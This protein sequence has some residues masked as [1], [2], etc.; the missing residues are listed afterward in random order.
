MNRGG[1][2]V[3]AITLALWTCGT[4][5]FAAVPLSKTITDGTEAALALAQ[6]GDF[7]AARAAAQ[8]NFDLVIAYGSN[9]DLDAFRAAD[10]ARRL[11]NQLQPMEPAARGD[12]LKYLRAHDELA[13]TLVF[14]ARDGNNIKG[15]YAL[16]DRLRKQRPAQVVE[17]ANLTAAIC[18]VRD[19]PL[20]NP[21]ER[22]APKAVDALDIFDF[23]AAHDS[24][25]F[26]GI[27]GMPVDLLVYVVDTT[28]SIDEMNWALAKY[29][30]TKNIGDLFFT[31]AYDYDFFEGKTPQRRAVVEGY[32]LPN[33]LKFGGICADQAYFATS[34]GKAIGVPTAYTVGESAESG[35]AWVGFLQMQGRTARWNFNS[36]R[37][38]AYQ[39]VRGNA[40]DPQS[41]KRLADS[42]VS[43]LA[44][45]I[46]ASP[47]ARQNAVAMVDAAKRLA[48]GKG[49]DGTY[50]APAS[51]SSSWAHT[52]AR[53]ASSQSELDL[54]EMGLVQCPTYSPGWGLVADLAGQGELTEAQKSRWSALVEQ[55]CGQK[56][57]DFTLAVLEPMVDT[58]ANPAEQ[59]RIWDAAFSEFQTRSDLAAEIRMH[60]ATLWE[61]SGDLAKAGICYEDVIHR[62]INAGPFALKALTGAEEILK[63]MGQEAKVL[64]LYAD[65]AKLV[66]KPDQQMA[67]MYFKESN[68]FKV[69]EAYAKKLDEAGLTNQ[70]SAIRAA[71]VPVGAG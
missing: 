41:N 10:F 3:G 19:R 16:L 29:V 57:P 32:T 60:Q 8:N 44:E 46:G 15:V 26:F 18:V 64:D 27:R 49:A 21:V 9:N 69:R 20:G 2:F 28:A 12:L 31:I 45:S 4:T 56:Y 34:V 65:A 33:I 47:V 68:F 61:K 71:N 23:Y 13:K 40:A 63:Q 42:Y 25:M 5:T 7:K 6:Q 48:G 66:V 58:V 59:S 22:S 30:G 1:I 43:L 24:Q 11:I 35:H 52:I 14:A 54:I 55:L 51:S 70:A 50:T 62:F 37:Y 38:E 67:M 17:F 36:G 39:G 53:S